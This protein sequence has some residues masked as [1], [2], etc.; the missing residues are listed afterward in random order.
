MVNRM[1]GKPSG[2]DFDR[3][4]FIQEPPPSAAPSTGRAIGLVLFLIAAVG[5]IFVAYKLMPQLVQQS[6]PSDPPAM[7]DIDRRLSMIESRLEKL[8]S[9]RQVSSIGARRQEDPSTE[10][11][12]VAPKPVVRT[13]YQVS[14]ASTEPVH[15]ASGASDPAA[16]QHI[17]ALQQR[18]GA[19]Q[20]E[21]TETREA[22]Q[23][24]TDK[25]ADMA[26]QVGSQGVEILKSQDQLN[27]LLSRTEMVAIPFELL[28][29][30]NP[31]PVGPVN[32][33]L[34]S[35][36]PKTLRYTVC[37]YVQPSC[38]ELKDRTLHEVVQFVV[39][40]N[41]SPLQMIATRIVKDEIVGYLQVP[42]D[43]SAH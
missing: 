22:W 41:T 36:N 16:S 21:Q 34:K 20:S 4:V 19:I 31:Q 10:P 37:V 14:P 15:D 17:A 26:G 6:S 11:K 33:V 30:S 12:Q 29:G 7:A 13:I 35:A 18:L 32:F 40:R 5:V 8:E 24:T 38:I 39:S 2:V 27:E 43:Q 28:K 9:E 3:Q 1:T 23:A 25:L 42:R